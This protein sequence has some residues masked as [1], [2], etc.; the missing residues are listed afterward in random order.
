MNHE[1]RTPL[2]HIIG[3]SELIMSEVSPE[4]NSIFAQGIHSSGQSLLS[5]IEDIFDL[6]LFEQANVRIRSHTFSIIDHFMEC[7]ASFDNILRA[8]SKHEQ[9]QLVFKPETHW[10]S[11]YVTTDRSKINQVLTNLFKNAVKFTEKGTIEFGY[12]IDSESNM[13]FFVTDTGIGI[14][15][16]KQSII[17][18]FFRQGDDD[19]KR[20]HGGIGI[21]LAIS[22]KIAKILNGELTVVS[23]PNIG[24]TFYL[25]VP[26]E[27][28]DISPD[29]KL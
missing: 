20:V 5:I 11:G 17:F 2:H 4:E 8:S 27:L 10:L 23:E 7:K 22:Q 25:K 1:L 12:K 15:K 28:S 9:I 21:G 16:E 18:D 14:P 29:I 6:A 24:S 13:I 19:I 3:F 26:V